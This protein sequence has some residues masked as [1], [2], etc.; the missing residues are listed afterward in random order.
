[1]KI[2][3]MNTTKIAVDAA[4]IYI[5]QKYGIAPHVLISCENKDCE[6]LYVKAHL[7]RILYEV[8]K[9]GICLILICSNGSNYN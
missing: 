4:T 9:T 7:V 2:K 5:N 6:T 1:M 3:C 8:I